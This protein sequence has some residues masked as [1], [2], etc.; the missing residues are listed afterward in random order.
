MPPSITDV[1]AVESEGEALWLSKE[2]TFAIIKILWE[3]GQRGLT[4]EEVLNRLKEMKVRV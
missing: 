1:T 2:P 3:G 4:V